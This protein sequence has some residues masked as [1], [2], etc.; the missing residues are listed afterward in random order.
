MQNGVGNAPVIRRSVSGV[1]IPAA[2]YVSA[3]MSG[4]GHLR[5]NGRGDLVIGRDQ[6]APGAVAAFD[7]ALDTVERLF[8]GAG[9]PCRRSAAIDVDL[10]SKL[11]MNCAYN[12]ISALGRSRYGRLAAEPATRAVLELAVHEL[13]AV[14]AAEGVDLSGANLVDAAH[15]LSAGFPEALSSTAQ[16]IALGRRTEIDD[17]NGYVVTR[18][19]AHGIATPVN[20]T[21]HALVKLLEDAPRGGA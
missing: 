10:W 12:A 14:A 13:E 11:A 8:V 9:V 7:E 19:A 20:Q 4:P 3:E 21:L 6:H 2:V 5:H 18:G 16:D 15:R 1:V 17:L